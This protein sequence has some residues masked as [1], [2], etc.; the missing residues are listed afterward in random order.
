ML[1]ASPIS[2]GNDICLAEVPESPKVSIAIGM[3]YMRQ[4]RL[5]I[6]SITTSQAMA[7]GPRV[8]RFIFSWLP[9]CDY[10]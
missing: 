6:L 5:N 4:V 3:N 7:D 8:A 9:A 1:C 2:L 10:K